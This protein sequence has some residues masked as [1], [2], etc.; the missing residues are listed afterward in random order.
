MRS[1]KKKRKMNQAIHRD[2]K[3]L[4]T[5]ARSI[6]ISSHMDPDGDSLGSQLAMRRYLTDLGKSVKIVNQGEISEKYKFLPDIGRV[7]PVDKYDNGDTFDL[8]VIF[9][10]PEPERTGDVIGLVGK[11]T[12]IINI[13]HHPDN[14]GYG[15]IVHVRPEAS[16]VGEMLAEY[17]IDD[18]YDIDGDTATQLY[19]AILTDT[20]RFRFNSTGCR[21]MEIAGLL[22]DKGADPRRISDNIYYSFSESTLH[23]IGRVFSNARLFDDGKICLIALDQKTLRENNFNSADT[24]GMAEYSLFGK[25]VVVGGLLKEVAEGKTKVSLRSRNVIDVCEVAHRYGGGGHSNASGFFIEL[26]LEA[27]HDKILSD[28]K[29]LVNGEV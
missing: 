10:C 1:P 11:T 9:E 28:L 2:I 18:G 27:A 13:D 22:I 16:A 4:I 21:T 12:K 8:V 19:T 15:D 14:T 6:L 23:L 17:F 26:P 25:G 29:E 24:E 5:T 3:D 20:G 7:I